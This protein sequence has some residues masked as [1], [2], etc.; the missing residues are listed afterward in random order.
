MDKEKYFNFPIMLIRE[1]FSDMHQVCDNIIDYAVYR[2]A[3]KLEGSADKQIKDSAKYFGITLGN[4][5]K[6]IRNGSRLLNSTPD[7]AVMTGLSKKAVFDFYENNKSDFE[8]GVLLANLAIKSILGNKSFCRITNEFL[9]CRMAGYGKKDEMTSLPPELEK[10]QK[11]YH[12]DKL[13]SELQSTYG[14]KIYARYTKGFFVSFSLSEEEL[15]RQVEMKRKRYFDKE[16]K[17]K[18]SKAVTK[19]LAELYPNEQKNEQK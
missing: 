11:R 8:K 2:H 7:K 18:V 15:I 13:K 9:L 6:T 1:A 12:I 17:G 3:Q 5:S 19:V 14:L 4:N 16:A 10:Y